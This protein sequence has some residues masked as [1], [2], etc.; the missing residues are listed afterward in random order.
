MQRTKLRFH[1]RHNVRLQNVDEFVD[2]RLR[3]F[4]FRELLI[5][6]DTHTI[7]TGHVGRTDPRVL[8]RVIEVAVCDVQ[9]EFSRLNKR[10][11]EFDSVR[12]RRTVRLRIFR[13][14]SKVLN[15]DLRL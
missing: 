5:G 6:E 7:T 8:L 13:R 1:T 4:P 14:P 11:I 10:R 9:K 2:S 15:D 12:W 3:N